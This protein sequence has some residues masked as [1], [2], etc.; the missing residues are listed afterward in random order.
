MFEP[1]MG[2]TDVDFVYRLLWAWLIV[3][4]SFSMSFVFFYFTR[5]VYYP[6]GKEMDEGVVLLISCFIACIMF[7]RTLIWG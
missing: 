3:L 5:R 6:R 7:F 4:I 1:S 2:K